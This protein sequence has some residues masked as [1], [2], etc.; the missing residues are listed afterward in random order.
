MKKRSALGNGVNSL[1]SSD[2]D[3]DKGPSVQAPVT[4]STKTPASVFQAPIHKIQPSLSQ[5]RKLFQDEDLE[6]LSKSIKEVGIIQPLIVKMD[7]KDDSFMIVAG[8]RRWRAAQKAGLHEVPIIL[9]ECDNKDMLEIALIEN[10]QRQDL[11]VIEEAEAYQMLQIKYNLNQEDISK[12]VGKDR[13]TITN[14]LR[15]LKLPPEIQRD[16]IDETLSMGHARALLA[17]ENKDLQLEVRNL[18]KIKDLNVRQTEQII[19]KL[20]QKKDQKNTLSRVYQ[21]NPN[22]LFLSESLQKYFGTK[23]TIKG[24]G[25]KGKIEISYHSFDDLERILDLMKSKNA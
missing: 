16:I 1:F 3:L 19:R 23:V 7:E 2:V 17:L 12:K 22:L 15:I 20:K 13:T 8:E 14:T 11:N 21:E 4:K 25:K 24:R 10:I 5:P 18:I 9:R 6:E